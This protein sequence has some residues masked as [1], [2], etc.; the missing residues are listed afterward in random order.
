MET[1]GYL[2]EH[3]P[4]MRPVR[5]LSHADDPATSK[6]AAKEHADSCRLKRNA[7]LVLEMVRR[8]PGATAA[9]LW[10]YTANVWEREQ[11]KELQEVR[12]R[13]TDLQAMGRVVAGEERA[14]KVRGTMMMTWNG[15]EMK[16]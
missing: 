6:A 16:A 13:L 10:E 1:Q 7:G 2:F 5:T 9:E 14:C 8:S 11:L 4:D 12:R 3:T 15:K